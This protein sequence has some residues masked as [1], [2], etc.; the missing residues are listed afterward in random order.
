MTEPLGHGSSS[1]SFPMNTN[2]TGFRLVSKVCVI[3]RWAKVASAV[4]GLVVSLHP[5][6]CEIY[7]TC[8]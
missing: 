4:E 7:L 3:V 8:V 6:C 1:E 2:M 5:H